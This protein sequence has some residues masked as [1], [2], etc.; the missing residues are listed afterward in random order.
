MSLQSEILDGLE[1][2]SW[3]ESIS[4]VKGTIKN[5]LRR[6]DPLA[7]IEDTSYFNHSFV[8]DFVLTWK[9][10][11]NR[12]RDVFL[13]LD[14][15]AAFLTGDLNHLARDKPLLLGLTAIGEG[16]EPESTASLIG[17]AG[18][19]TALVIEP[20]A[21]DRFADGVPR[22]NFGQVLP[23][24][25]LKGGRGWVN[26]PAAEA[27]TTAASDFFGG[28]RTHDAD[29]VIAAAPRLSDYLDST[30]T[31]R[32]YHLGR[33]VWEATGGEPTRFPMPLQLIGL[34]DAGLRFLM[35]EAP[36]DDVAFWRSVGQ[37]VSL[38]RL[39]RLGAFEGRN[40]AAFVRPNA[41]RLLARSL[42]V[43][44]SQPQLEDRGPTWS[45]ESG[46]LAVRGVDFTAYFTPP[47]GALTV[48]ADRRRGLSV[49]DFQERTRLQTVETVVVLAPD[50]KRVR[51]ES[52]DT[53]FAPADDPVLTSVGGRPGTTVTKV[54]L[55]VSGKSLECDFEYGTASG[56]T[57]ATF[58]IVALLERAL[59]MLWP[60]TDDRD[61]AEVALVRASINTITQPALFD[62][63]ATGEVKPINIVISP[64]TVVVTT[65]VDDDVAVDTDE[66]TE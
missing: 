62:D 17:R 27:L 10:D 44:R 1:I 19:S 6:M 34:D 46:G 52:P 45:I 29:D 58:E 13:R 50:R 2:A 23:P 14:T 36:T 5:A 15:S 12:A 41:D 24:A 59:P 40:L 55:V 65:D 47:G 20:E 32:L 61:R 31:S 57:N 56:H 4:A 60:L 39:L 11:P 43:K 66:A 53:T 26:E 8:P 64:G 16:S 51:I 9:D 30:Q 22:A 49:S 3:D 38:E 35:E 7:R 42:L 28:A 33:V 37:Q 54:G 18:E 21:V 63:A 25:I 48:Q